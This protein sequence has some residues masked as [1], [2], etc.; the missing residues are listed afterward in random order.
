MIELMKSFP[1]LRVFGTS[2]LFLI[3]DLTN[4][5]AV[6]INWHVAAPM[7]SARENHVATLLGNGQVLVVGG[8]GNNGDDP[9]FAEL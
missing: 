2:V 6:T 4:G 1:A 3:F 8:K 5:L 9:T 7:H